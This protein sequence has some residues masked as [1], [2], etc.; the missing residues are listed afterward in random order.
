MSLFIILFIVITLLAIMDYYSQ[1]NIGLF[2]SAIILVIVAGIRYN[3][4][5]D[6]HS[7]YWYYITGE[8]RFEKGFNF[9][10]SVGHSLH[11][12]VFQFQIFYSFLTI[13]LL[14]YFLYKNV[15]PGIGGFAI[16]YYFSRFYWVRD[17]GQIRSSLASIICLYSIK[18]IREKRIIPFL[19]VIL[20]AGSIHRGAFIFVAAYFIANVFNKDIKLNKTLVLLGLAYIV[21]IILQHYP[22]IIQKLTNESAYSVSSQYTTNSAG[23]AVTLFMQMGIILIYAILKKYS[24]NY[25]N[26]FMDTIANVYFTGTLVAIS[27]LG[28]RTLGYRLDTILNTVEIIMVP[29]LIKKAITNKALI[30]T[31]NIVACALVF[32]MIMFS[33]GSYMNFMPFNTMF[34][35]IK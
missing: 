10:N 12:D 16:L 5:Y 35:P 21:G 20:I 1:H 32:Y 28:Y 19:F 4:G 17:L 31:L 2:I 3:V 29:F 11:L 30:V 33:D 26:K 14:A 24:S 34:S 15:E 9:L 27:L 7:Y 6:Y 13:G 22:I 18:Y 23:S 8:G 25:E